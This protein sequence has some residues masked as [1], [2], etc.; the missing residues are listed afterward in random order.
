MADDDNTES[1]MVPD[2]KLT[3]QVFEDQLN[4]YLEDIGVEDFSELSGEPEHTFDEWMERITK[5]HH[6]QG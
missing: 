2:K 1:K 6:A 5:L 4:S 3:Q